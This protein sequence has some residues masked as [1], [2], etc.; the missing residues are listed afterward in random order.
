MLSN[1][2]LLLYSARLKYMLPTAVWNTS[3]RRPKRKVILYFFNLH[4]NNNNNNN[5]NY[6]VRVL[7]SP[8]FIRNAYHGNRPPPPSTKTA[9]ERVFTD[10]S[11]FRF[12]SRMFSREKTFRVGERRTDYPRDGIK[13]PDLICFISESF[14]WRTHPIYYYSNLV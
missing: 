12:E 7:F 9:N 14:L 4:S 1:W 3:W 13:S 2:N 6:M 5:Y 8:L 11:G 10:F